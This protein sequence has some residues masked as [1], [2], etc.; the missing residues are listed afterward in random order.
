VIRARGGSLWQIAVGTGRDAA[1]LCIPAAV[2]AAAAAIVVVP[3][4]GSAQGAGSAGGWWPPIA[5]AVV[6]I[7]GPALIAAWQHRL[8]RR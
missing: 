5:V 6:A 2:I 4:A 7:L 8:R 3:G 1:L